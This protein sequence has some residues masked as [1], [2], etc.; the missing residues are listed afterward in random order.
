MRSFLK[1]SFESA[2]G[3]ESKPI[4]IDHC[5]RRLFSISPSFFLAH[6]T[7]VYSLEGIRIILFSLSTYA[8]Y[9][10]EGNSFLGADSILRLSQLCCPRSIE[11]GLFLNLAFHSWPVFQPR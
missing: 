9:L 3:E 10:R 1:S 2:L 6:S 11:G 7:L 4:A 5:L 8:Y